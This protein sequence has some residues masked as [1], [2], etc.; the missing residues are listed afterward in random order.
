MHDKLHEWAYL[1]AWRGIRLLPDNVADRLFRYGADRSFRRGG[2][3]VDQ[4]RRNL[5]RVTGTD[6][7][8]AML[9]TALRSYARYWKEAFRLPS[10]SDR[11]FAAAFEMNGFEPVAERA[12]QG[13][14]SIVA[15]PHTGNW[16]LAGAWVAKQGHGITAVVER[17]KP[18]GVYR[19]FVEFRESL[20]MHVIPTDGSD[21]A[22][23]ALL[24]N[25]LQ[26]GD[27]VALVADRDLSDSGIDVDF[28]NATASFPAG[29]AYL[30]VRHQVPLYTASIHYEDDR[31]VCHISGPVDTGQGRLRERMNHTTQQMA[32]MFQK[33]IADHPTDWHMMQRFWTDQ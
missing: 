33:S 3:R 24:G 9:R 15:L 31:A 18:E 25:R 17:L 13:M 19:R 5:E 30:A 4:L 29:P 20:G 21:T 16:D 28:F 27:V 6:V 32:D 23:L 22:P 11:A 10:M 2:P 8:D 26:A 1:T 7:D 14:G 12:R